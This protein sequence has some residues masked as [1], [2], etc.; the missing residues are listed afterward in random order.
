[1]L[2]LC[3]QEDSRAEVDMNVVMTGAGQFVELQATAEKSA[4]GD[5]HLASLLTLARKGVGE[6]IEVQRKFENA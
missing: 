6:L 3:Y 4:F 1:M 2:D 5:S